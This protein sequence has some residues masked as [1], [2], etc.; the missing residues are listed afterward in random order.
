MHGLGVQGGAYS[1][2]GKKGLREQ[3][4]IMYVLGST[5]LALFYCLVFLL[6]FMAND[7]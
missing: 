5:S 6:P 2:K 7:T 1:K 4:V 3:H